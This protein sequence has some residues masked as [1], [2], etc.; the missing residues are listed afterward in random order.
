MKLDK[1]AQFNNSFFTTK[2]IEHCLTEKA[3]KE[4]R[5][6]ISGPKGT[7]IEM[8][9]KKWAGELGIIEKSSF[10]FRKTPEICVE[11]AKMIKCDQ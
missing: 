8:A 5:F 7:N 11:D 3:V 4:I 9:S 2:D 10:H 1:L 6:F